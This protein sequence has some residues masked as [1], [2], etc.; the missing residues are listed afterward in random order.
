[1][2]RVIFELKGVHFSYQGK[3]PALCDINLNIEEGSKIVIMGAN[4][5]GKTTL[6]M[7]LDALIF[8]QKGYIRVFGR[9]LRDNL[10]NDWEFVKFFRSKVGLLFQNPDVQLFSPTVKDDL[11][12]SL[13]NL[14][15]AQKEIERRL[16]KIVQLFRIK[17]LL[18]R[19]P[20]QLS[21]G[22]KKKVAI[23]SVLIMEPEVLLLDEPTAGL[24]PQTTRDIM[25]II[26]KENSLGKTIVT[27]THHLEIVEELADK[28]YVLGK[29]NK[30]VRCDYPKEILYDEEFL[31]KNNLAHI[32]SHHH[33]DLVHT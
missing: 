22:E 2:A 3:I 6:L 16:S 18:N 20:H 24:D 25:D 13:L 10:L 28:V 21:V 7:L 5:T 8:P 23:A 31:L 26:I 19:V 30:I 14:G 11:L 1:M 27:A 15:F 33:K 17:E 9:E 32:H 12:F 29:E 4:G